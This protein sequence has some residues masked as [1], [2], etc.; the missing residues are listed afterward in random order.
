MDASIVV[1]AYNQTALLRTTLPLVRDQDF[2]GEWEVIVCDDGSAEDTLS[3]LRSVFRR[4][5]PPVRYIWQSR[6]SPSVAR[7]RNNGLRVAGGNV[8][9]LLDGDMA[10][11]PDFLSR[12]VAE[13]KAPRTAVCGTR[14]WLFLRDLGDICNLRSIVASLLKRSLEKEGLY[15]EEAF[16]RKYAASPYPW[17]SSMS[18]NLSLTGNSQVFFDEAFIGWGAEDHEF[19]CRLNLRHGFSIQLNTSLCALHLEQ[20]SLQEFVP[21]RPENHAQIVQYLQNVL[22]FKEAYPEV[23]MIAA[24]VGLGYYELD[25]ESNLWQ[26]TT[27]PKFDR[28]HISSLLSQ[29]EG[30]LHRQ[31]SQGKPAPIAL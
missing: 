25:R 28:N 19:A 1:T 11:P 27:Q 26:R 13:H 30:W 15:S 24:C 22:R 14:K 29:A 16:Q 3:V 8:V 18:C 23:D 5:S 7:S 12:H 9:L 6:L 2:P 20:R 4:P 17:I 31:H 21:M 10:I